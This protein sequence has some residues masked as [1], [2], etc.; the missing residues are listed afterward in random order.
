MVDIHCHILPGID[1]GAE[2]ILET[3]EMA[4]LASAD[5]TRHI[6]ATPHFNHTFLNS[7]EVVHKLVPQ[8]QHAI[9]LAGVDITIHPG[10]EVRLESKDFV[11]SHTLNKQYCYLAGNPKFLLLEQSWHN[12]YAQTL[13][14]IQWFQERGTRIIIPHPERHSFFRNEPQLLVKLIEAGVWTQ[15]SVDSLLGKNS[16]AA[17]RLAEW[18]IQHNYVHML[19]T[20]A[21]NIRRKPNLSLG[22]DIVDHLVGS[23][24]VQ[25]MKDRAWSILPL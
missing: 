5:G 24:R 12:Y 10:N 20:D 4:K 6:I 17:Q 15:V 3:I 1:D 18:L 13:E 14:I 23:A 9:D 8:V 11:V 21:H 7:V 2:N 22:F 16:D 19:A 25:E